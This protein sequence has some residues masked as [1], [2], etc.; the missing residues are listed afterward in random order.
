M[1]KKN[2]VIVGGG[3]AGLSL[4][5]KLDGTLPKTHRIVL[6]EPQDFFYVRLAAAR[7]ATS[8]DIAEQVLVPYDKLFKT[9]E[10]GVVVRAAVTEIKPHSV[11]LSQPH[12]LFGSEVE[13]DILVCLCNPATDDRSLQLEVIGEILLTCTQLRGKT[14]STFWQKSA[15]K[16]PPPMTL[17]SSGRVQSG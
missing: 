13:F 1:S 16:L 5:N 14:P 4:I 10:Q 8:E 6:I 7:V 15:R 11:K 9:P 3:Y 17:S 2:I 12:K